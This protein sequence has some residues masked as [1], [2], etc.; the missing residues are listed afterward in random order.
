MTIHRTRRNGRIVPVI[1]GK[2]KE[3]AEIVQVSAQTPPTP[4]TSNGRFLPGF[5]SPNPGGRT[6]ID[7]DFKRAC[8]EDAVRLRPM[9]VKAI[10]DENNKLSD[11]KDLYK[12]LCEYAFG[13]PKQTTDLT[14]H[15]PAPLQIIS[16][17]GLLADED[18]DQ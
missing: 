7:R 16:V 6:I 17:A 3:A 13:K 5:S 11:R 1:N 18:I 10:E 12:L 2:N 14:L 4:R 15:K 9:M 8:Q